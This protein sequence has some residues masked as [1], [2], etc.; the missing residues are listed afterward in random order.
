MENTKE[1]VV[2]FEER[3]NVKVRRQVKLDKTEKRDFRREKLLG[4]YIVKILYR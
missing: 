4:K 3:M 1:V 2:G